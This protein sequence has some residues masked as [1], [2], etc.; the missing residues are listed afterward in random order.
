MNITFTGKEDIRSKALEDLCEKKISKLL[1][2]V[3]TDNVRADVTFSKEAKD[4]V[5]SIRLFVDGDNY[6]AKVK[7]DDMYKN[8]DDCVTKLG[9]Q[10]RKK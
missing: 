3:S 2:K 8:V 5:L 9:A 7:G 4:Y 10:L 1:T 6:M